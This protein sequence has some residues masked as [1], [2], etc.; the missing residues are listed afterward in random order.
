MAAVVDLDEMVKLRAIT[1]DQ[2]A[3]GS[4]QDLSYEVDW[5]RVKIATEM[6]D[7]EHEKANRKMPNSLVL[8]LSKFENPSSEEQEHSFSVRNKDTSSGSVSLH[9]SLSLDGRTNDGMALPG[10]ALKARSAVW[11]APVQRRRT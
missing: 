11:S 9:Q 3:N 8:V 7:Y 5:S 2:I 4:A 1:A 10:D 6:P